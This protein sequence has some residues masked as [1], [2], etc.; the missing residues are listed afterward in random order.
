MTSPTK[1]EGSGP[2][3][4]L[5][6][7]LVSNAEPTEA[8]QLVGRSPGQLMWHRFKRDRT[9]VI[10]ACVVIFFFAVAAL[11]PVISSLYGKDP[12]TLYAQEPDYPFLLDDFA[13][14]TGSFGGISGD[15]WFGVE[16]KLGRDVLTM[17]LYGMRT[18]L[19][20]AVLVTVF[21][22]LTGVV[23]GMISGYFGGKVDYWLGRVTDFFLAFPQQLFFIAFMPVVTALFVSPTDETPTY[24]RAVAIILVMWFLGWMGM[25]RLVRS[26]VLS[27]RER[28]FV[29]AAKVSGASP[30]RIVR[31][32]I[33]PN[34]VTPIL[35]QGT[36]MLPSSILSIAFLSYVGV[37]FTEPTPDWG[38]MF[39]IGAGIYEQDPAFM[40]F[41]GIAMVVF[42]LAFNL[43]GDSVRDAFDPKTGR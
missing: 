37:G 26:S 16:P 28:E 21:S 4:A 20:M 23:L 33:L 11:A 22:V 7:E 42:V 9:G 31:K 32:E 35:V 25:A 15:F 14:P 5:D 3:A 39:A 12:Y 24:L 17:L 40:F 13:M 36:Y 30:A 10:S 38:R 18:S 8:E 2:S 27:L 1:A 29:E 6:P 43:L 41:P 19:Y 34:I